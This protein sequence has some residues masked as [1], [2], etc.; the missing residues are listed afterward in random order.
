MYIQ[1]YIFPSCQAAGNHVE[2]ITLD[3]VCCT[4][5]SIASIYNYNTGALTRVLL[6]V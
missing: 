3:I 5:D 2:V 1:H 4:V 6:I